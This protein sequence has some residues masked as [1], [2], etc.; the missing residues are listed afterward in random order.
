MSLGTD[1]RFAGACSL[2]VQPQLGSCRGAASFGV[3]PPLMCSL[4]SKPLALLHGPLSSVPGEGPVSGPCGATAGLAPDSSA[5][6]AAWPPGG[7]CTWEAI[8]LAG[9]PC[10]P[11]STSAPPVSIAGA[12]TATP[13]RWPGAMRA[14]LTSSRRFWTED[15]LS[16][17]MAPSLRLPTCLAMKRPRGLSDC[18]SHTLSTHGG[19][20]AA[21]ESRQH[22]QLR[23]TCPG[24]QVVPGPR[25]RTPPQGSQ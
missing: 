1:R 7:H 20:S 4:L 14:P 18:S 8:S 5:L 25:G 22:C 17:S 19:S 21:G 13:P 24:S 11:P 15:G 23:G 6:Q 10:A 16:G 12:V 3:L 2:V 9:H